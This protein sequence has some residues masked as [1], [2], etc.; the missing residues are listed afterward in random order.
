MSLFDEM[1]SDQIDKAAPDPHL[2]QPQERHAPLPR[3]PDQIEADECRVKISGLDEEISDMKFER[4]NLTDRIMNLVSE[5]RKLA[6]ELNHIKVNLSF[7]EKA[8]DGNR[9]DS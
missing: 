5:R 7:W 2:L 8:D 1:A 9:Q 4:Q 3:R 6:Y